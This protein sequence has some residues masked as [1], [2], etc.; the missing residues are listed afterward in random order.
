MKDR[1]IEYHWLFKVWFMKNYTGMAVTPNLII[2][3]GYAYDGLI[4]HERV[5]QMQMR[6]SGGLL[7]FWLLYLWYYLT[8]LVK[9]KN[10]WRAYRMNPLE[11]EARN[12]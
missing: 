3:R 5:H 11:V 8:G 9:Y 10:H 2:C 1:V 7:F 12:A 4:K 6:R